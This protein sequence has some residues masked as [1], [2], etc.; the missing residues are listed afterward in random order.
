VNPDEISGL[1]ASL[2]KA[3]SARIIFRLHSEKKKSNWLWKE[4]ANHEKLPEGIVV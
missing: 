1:N 4:G 2:S 3:K